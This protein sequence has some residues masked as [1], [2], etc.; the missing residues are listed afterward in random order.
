MEGWEEGLGPINPVIREGYLY[1][2][3]GA[4]DGYS[5]FSVMLAIKNLQE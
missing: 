5:V 3:G 1:G 2:R 4:D